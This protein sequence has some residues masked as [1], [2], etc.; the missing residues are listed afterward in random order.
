MDKNH[1]VEPVTRPED[2]R[3]LADPLIMKATV[4]RVLAMMKADGLLFCSDPK[5][6]K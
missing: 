6:A 5:K 1:T 2:I 4:G 3:K